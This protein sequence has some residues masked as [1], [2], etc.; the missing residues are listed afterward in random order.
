MLKALQRHVVDCEVV[1]IDDDSEIEALHEMQTRD[2]ARV[3]AN[4]DYSDSDE[5]VLV[6]LEA[7]RTSARRFAFLYA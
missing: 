5:L 1:A 6:K 4:Y 3:E 7:A 2:A